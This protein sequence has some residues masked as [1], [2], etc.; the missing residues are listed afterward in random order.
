MIRRYETDRRFM[1]KFVLIYAIL[2]HIRPRQNPCMIR[3]T[4]FSHRNSIQPK[5]LQNKST[6][7]AKICTHLHCFDSCFML[8]SVRARTRAKM[9]VHDFHAPSLLRNN[10]SI[11]A[12]LRTHLCYFSSRFTLKSIQARTHTRT[13]IRV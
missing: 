5:S 8:K 9:D 12:K 11:Y 3:C 10:S 4:R 7:Y 6:I 13:C 2:V 1:L